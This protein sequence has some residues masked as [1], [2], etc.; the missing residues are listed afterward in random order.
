V[1]S[2]R[3]LGWQQT[4]VLSAALELG[5]LEEVREVRRSREVAQSLGLDPRAVGVVLEALVPLGVVEREEECLYRLR[6]EHDGPLLDPRNEEYAG[7]LV[8]D[9]ADEISA[10]S[11]LTEVLESGEPVRDR[12]ASSG[13]SGGGVTETFV[14]RMRREALPG[15]EVTAQALLTRLRSGATILDVGGGP[16]TIAE[17]LARGGARVTVFDL[18]EVA[19]MVRKRL[20]DSGIHVE[21]GDMNESLPDGP[22][23]AVYLGHTSHMYGPEENRELFRRL[24]EVLAPGGVLAVRDFVQ[25]ESEGAGMFAVNMLVST[26]LGGVYSRDEYRRWMEAA[27]FEDFEVERVPGRGTHLVLG[28]RTNGG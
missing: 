19:G 4:L 5:L 21:A 15:A 3:E 27:G 9:R 2:Y 18:P 17:A 7:A 22:F 25:G 14:E 12:T 16:G 23:D 1:S 10:W 13:V 28:R 26:R 20:G 24:Y 6:E 8:R 11:R